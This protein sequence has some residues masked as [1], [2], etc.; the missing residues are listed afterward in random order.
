MQDDASSSRPIIFIGHSFGGLV[1]E[2]AIVK[3]NS[4]GGR[5]EPLIKLLGGVVLLGTPHQGSKVQKLGSI[6]ANLARLM[7]YGE[8]IL[9]EELEEN[10]TKILDMISEFMKIMIR[11][12][13]AEK[14]VICFFENMQTDY[15]K[16]VAGGRWLQGKASAMVRI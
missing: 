8:T 14:A 1:I 10:S 6:I 9:M 7:D 3:A 12:D 16:R 5:Y 11:T 2:Q 13:L 15:S 4:A